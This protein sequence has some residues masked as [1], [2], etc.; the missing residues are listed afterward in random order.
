[1]TV[2]CRCH[3]CSYVGRTDDKVF[4]AIERGLQPRQR[5]QRHIRQYLTSVCDVKV[6]KLYKRPASACI[7]SGLIKSKVG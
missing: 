2:E 3:E 6:S 7:K 4:K 1:M 5:F